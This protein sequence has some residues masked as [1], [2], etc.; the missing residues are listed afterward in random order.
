MEVRRSRFREDEA[1]EE[2]KRNG[3]GEEDEDGVERKWV[4]REKIEIRICDK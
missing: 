1:M 3:E 2:E 4:W